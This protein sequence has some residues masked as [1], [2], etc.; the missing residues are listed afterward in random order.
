VI[1]AC[2]PCASCSDSIGRQT[3]QPQ[4]L[5]ICMKLEEVMEK[6][7]GLFANL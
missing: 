6:E 7:K 4:W 2:P 1:R 5:A 3:G